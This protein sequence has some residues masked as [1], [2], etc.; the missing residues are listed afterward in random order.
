MIRDTCLLLLLLN[1]YLQDITQYYKNI[2]I[3]DVEIIVCTKAR[4]II[5]FTQIIISHSSL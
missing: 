2:K 1:Q 5:I 4:T 3:R